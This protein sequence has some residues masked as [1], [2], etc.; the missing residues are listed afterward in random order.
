MS[1]EHEPQFRDTVL[2]FARQRLFKLLEIGHR[3]IGFKAD[4]HHFRAGFPARF[5]PAARGFREA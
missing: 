2:C 5:D 3:S 4:R 1:E